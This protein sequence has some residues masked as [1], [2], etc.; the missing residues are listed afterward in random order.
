MKKKKFRIYDIELINFIKFNFNTFKL[1]FNENNYITTINS[2][3]LFY[4][5]S[6]NFYIGFIQNIKFNKYNGIINISIQLT[7][8]NLINKY[9]LNF[10]NFNFDNININF[11][12]KVNNNLLY[13]KDTIKITNTNHNYFYTLYLKKY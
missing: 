4:K 7:N 8:Y 12:Y 10:Y 6:N 11:K 9:N 5:N 1:S 13:N 2:T 3:F